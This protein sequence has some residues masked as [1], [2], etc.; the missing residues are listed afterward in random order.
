MPRWADRNGIVLIYAKARQW[1]RLLGVELQV[2]HV[3]PLNSKIVCGLHIPANLQLLD[4]G[5][6]LEK[7]NYV[8]PDMP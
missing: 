1:S 5:L 6:N 2:D 3:V 7:R 8:W 4:A